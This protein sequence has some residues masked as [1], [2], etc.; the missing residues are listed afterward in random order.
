MLNRLLKCILYGNRNRKRKQN[1]PMLPN[2]HREVQL[3]MCNLK[4]ITWKPHH[5]TYI[6]GQF[7][8]YP[9]LEDDLTHPHLKSAFSCSSPKIQHA[10]SIH[11]VCPRVR[12]RSVWSQVVSAVK[13][14]LQHL[15]NL[16]KQPTEKSGFFFKLLSPWWRTRQGLSWM[17]S[18]LWAVQGKP[19]LI[20]RRGPLWSKGPSIPQEWK[21]ST[22]SW[23]AI[24]QKF[25]ASLFA[26][27]VYL[28][29]AMSHGV[30]P[31][32]WQKEMTQKLESK[33][34]VSSHSWS[35]SR[36]VWHTHSCF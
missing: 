33:A 3:V 31:L 2:S 6:S 1:Q 21:P 22:C 26:P 27:L 23:N 5:D 11:S 18:R 7:H 4:W 15:C 13:W 36:Q 17:S 12:L 35:H 19:T 20:N 8:C 9:P 30:T 34:T 28:F 32:R 24:P 10:E 16:F 29:L 14:S 25:K